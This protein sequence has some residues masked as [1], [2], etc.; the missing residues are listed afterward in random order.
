[1]KTY[2]SA[3]AAAALL[4]LASAPA[5]ASTGAL[6]VR[7]GLTLAG[8]PIGTATVTFNVADGGP[9]KINAAA[10]VGGVMS[11]LS[12]GRGS[13]SAAGRL[14]PSQPQPSSYALNSISGKKPQT[15]QLAL[16]NGAVTAA[17]IMPEPAPR[18]DRVPVTLADKR[19]VI[20][21]LSA[22]LVPVAGSVNVLSADAC[23]RKLPIFDG[24]QRFDIP[25][26]YSRTEQVRGKGY[27]GPVI[28]CSARYIPIAGHRPERAQTK[29][30]EDNRD[31]EFW[32][33][34][35]GGT[36]VLAPWRIV[37]GTQIGRLTIDTIRYGGGD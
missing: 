4:G 25:L 26:T 9:Y 35:I 17:A 19:G 23:R 33:A 31:L 27:D 16:A 14:G 18:P 6:V 7:Y 11:L 36:H 29:F 32:L 37:V 5:L 30:M 12:D 13:A 28:V 8:L 10:K 2:R 24:A 34:P 21:P 20:D 1:M 15:V 22:L 3:F